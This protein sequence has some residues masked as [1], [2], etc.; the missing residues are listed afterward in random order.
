MTDNSVP[1]A[2]GLASS[3]SGFAAL[4]VAA[5][6]AAG[7]ALAPGELS[8]LARLGSGSA[9]RSIF[10]GF[11]EMARGARADG[12]DAAAHPLDAGTGWNVRLVVAIT[13]AGEKA[14]G[15]TAAMR[16]TA[17][18]SP[19]YEA[20]VR[21]VDGNL[22]AARAAI[23]GRDLAALG[24]VAERSAMRM[25][26]SAMAAEPP[27]LYWNPA[28]IAAIS[29]VRALRAE[30]ASAFFTIDAG[31]TSRCCGR[32]PGRGGR[33]GAGGDAG[34]AADA[35]RG[36]GAG[37]ASRGGRVTITAPG[38][39]FFAGEY[40]V[41]HGGTAVVAA[42]NRRVVARFVPGA[43]PS[44]LVV[45]EAIA[46]VRAHC[47]TTGVSFPDG[48]PGIDSASLSDGGQKL[49]LGSSAAVAAAAV[50]VLLEAAGFDVAAERWLTFL[51]AD[52]AHRAAQGGRGR[53]PTSPRR[54]WAAS[55]PIPGPR[56]AHRACA[57]WSR[58]PSSRWWSCRPARR[59]RPLVMSPPSSGW[60]GAIPG[61]TRAVC[62][63]I[64]R[65]ADAFLLGYEAGDTRGLLQAVG[66]AHDALAAL[67]RDADLGSSRRRWTLRPRWPASWAG[68][69]SPPARAAVT[70]ASP[71][72][73]IETR[74]QPSGRGRRALICGFL[75]SSP[76]RG[77]SG[78][79][80]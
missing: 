31:P 59:A 60:P 8:V 27:I 69:R 49:G 4:A 29:R 67:G 70:S 52:R 62:G 33:G 58:Q 50:G 36:A 21:G 78:A 6:G 7:L 1:T 45:A 10:G 2:S 53:A 76:A 42:V 35:D 43:A 28:T 13:A 44:T 79:R 17:E 30:G 16:R 47:A 57:R 77:A 74:R 3:A 40:G 75:V 15:S 55:S 14:L 51:F 38:K 61:R 56:S 46:A 25:H 63:R 71:S 66:A 39:L 37:R 64:R 24:A 12:S 11:V 72:F 54:S 80:H 18:T 68:R 73:P 5:T 26:A 41:L 34:R 20:W 65:A 19:Y 23:A 48:A 22:A 32:A 9:A